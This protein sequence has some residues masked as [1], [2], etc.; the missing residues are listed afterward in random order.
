MEKIN[1]YSKIT[2]YI[3]F[4]LLGFSIIFG[5]LPLILFGKQEVLIMKIIWVVIA[6]LCVLFSIFGLVYHKQYV[7]IKENKLILKNLLYTMKKLDISDC[8]YEIAKLPSYV[9]RTYIYGQWICVYS[10]RETKK[11]KYGFSN[12]KKYERIQLMYNE[13]NLDLIKSY[14]DK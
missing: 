12:S 2:T 3:Y 4:M 10:N 7:Y 8:Y 14:F 11:F 5:I 6:T 13:K 9:C 1:C